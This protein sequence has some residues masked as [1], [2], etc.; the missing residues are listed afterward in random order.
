MRKLPLYLFAIL[1]FSFL[2]NPVRAHVA[3]VQPLGGEGFCVGDTMEIKWQILINHSTNNWDLAYSKDAG[4]TWLPIQM[5]LPVSPLTYSWIIPSI[6]TGPIQIRVIMDNVGQNYQDITGNIAIRDQPGSIHVPADYPSIQQAIDASCDGDTVEI[7]QGIYFEN[8]NLLNRHIVLSGEFGSLM[9]TSLIS[10]VII[11]GGGTGPVLTIENGQDSNLIIQGLTL[12]NG[13]SA[14]GGGIFINNSRP[15]IR[16]NV[17]INNNGVLGGGIYINGSPNIFNN[18]ITQNISDSLGGGIFLANNSFPIMLNNILWADSA[19]ISGQEIFKS[20]ASIPIITWNDIEGGWTGIGNLD[21]DPEFCF[22]DTGNYELMGTSCCLGSGSGADNIG[23]QGQGCLLLNVE[24]AFG[25]GNMIKAYPNPF[26]SF[27]NLEF[28][29]L[30]SDQVT[31]QIFNMLGES[32]ELVYSKW[33]P[34]GSNSARLELGKL[35][36]GNYYAQIKAGKAIFTKRF[37]KVIP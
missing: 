20:V 11:D 16:N 29:I 33:F 26:T 24:K 22:P 5:D 3:F 15:T 37:L 9:D 8:I 32:T 35:P 18:T 28:Y 21:C 19:N 7:H 17:I 23:A 6:G 36:V 4:A 31:I 27:I 12:R 34:A 25:K 30:E 10:R 13:M 2:S 14:M 1:Y